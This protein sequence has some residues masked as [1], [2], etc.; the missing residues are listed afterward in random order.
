MTRLQLLNNVDHHDLRVIARHAAD[1]G[2]SVNQVLVFP[3]EFDRVQREYPILFRLDAEEGL[4]AVALLGLDPDENLFLDESGWQ[5]RY[6]PAIQQR[7]PFSIAIQS[8]GGEPLV[9]IDLDDPRVGAAEGLPLFLPHG[10]NTPY[11]EHVSRALG[12]IYGGIEAARTAYAA[13]DAF[14]LLQPTRL[15]IALDDDRR[16]IVS[17]YLAID[18]ERLA[19][20]DGAALERLNRAGHLQLAVLAAASLGNVGWLI[21]RK[22]RRR[23]RA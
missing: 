1:Y 10:G 22:N 11:L 21:E 2:D 9:H 3:T 6:I 13:F 7:G 17:D 16:Y 5:A 19:V 8:E 18:P 20:L 12:M 23:G 14:G 15:E 4:Q